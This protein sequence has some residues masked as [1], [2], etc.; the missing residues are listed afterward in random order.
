MFIFSFAYYCV[1]VRLVFVTAHFI[2]FMF[3][4]LFLKV[5]FVFLL[6]TFINFDDAFTEV[7]YWDGKL[8]VFICCSCCCKSAIVIGD[9][10]L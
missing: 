7:L 3:M 1:I 5:Y 6:C 4:N 9:L 8:H 10:Q 2:Y